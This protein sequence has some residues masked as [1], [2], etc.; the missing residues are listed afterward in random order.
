[1]MKLTPTLKFAALA[2]L[3]AFVSCADDDSV[4]IT[5]EGENPDPNAVTLAPEV[6]VY[7]ADKVHNNLTLAVNAGKDFAFLVDKT[8]QKVH[9][10]TFDESLGND[11]EILP[12]GKLLGIFKDPNAQIN[13]G[14]HGGI[15]KIMN[16]NG[17]VEWEYSLSNSDFILHHD[18][19]ML[20]NGNVLLLVWERIA[21]ADAAAQGSTN[22]GDIYPETLMEIDINTNSLVWQWRSYEHI[23][24]DDDAALPN[25]GIVAD[26]PHKINVN[27]NPIANGDLMHANGFDYDSN[28]DVIYLSVN[29]YS[30]VWVIDHSTT[31][32]EAATDAGGIYG[33]GGDLVYR[34]GNPRAYDN[35]MGEVRGDRNHYPNVLEN[36]VQGEGNML[37]Y[38]NGFA[39]GFS[40]VYE[41]E[42]PTTFSLTPNT[43]NEPTVVWSYA[44]TDIFSSKISGAERLANGNTLICEGDFGFWEV[45]PEKEI[46]WRY[47]GGEDS[48]FWRAYDYEVDGPILAAFGL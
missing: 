38:V 22:P 14:G 23:I 21:E 4:I 1:M 48:F 2:I 42:I 44:N 5:P 19:E 34:F 45:T 24:Q 15:V 40:T 47:N 26:N 27:Y 18:V 16:L 11:L 37:L 12:N 6:E 30:E 25:Y 43:D 17:D 13:F 46:V 10:F 8:G 33:K 36:G 31:T 28:K 3:F 32:A 20:P 35:M 41:L 7:E 39:A 9:E 29:F